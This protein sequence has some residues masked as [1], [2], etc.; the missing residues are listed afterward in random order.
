MGNSASYAVKTESAHARLVWASR[1]TSLK[2][3]W[4]W[5]SPDCRDNLTQ[6]H[7]KL[8]AWINDWDYLRC[9]QQKR[10]LLSGFKIKSMIWNQTYLL[11]WFKDTPTGS[12]LNTYQMCT[13]VCKYWERAEKKRPKCQN[14]VTAAFALKNPNKNYY[15]L[16]TYII[17]NVIWIGQKDSAIVKD[18]IVLINWAIEHDYMTIR[19]KITFFLYETLWVFIFFFFQKFY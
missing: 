11:Q 10:I 17:I 4:S 1:G 6:M 9:T 19:F 13:W 3:F 15:L 2:T 12:T 18:V 5:K 16:I 7:C 14:V 8:Q